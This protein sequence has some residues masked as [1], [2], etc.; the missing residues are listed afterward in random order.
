MRP[1]H[2]LKLR[3]GHDLG[4]KREKIVRVVR[5]GQTC[6]PVVPFRLR[7]RIPLYAWVRPASCDVTSGVVN[8]G[9]CNDGN[10]N[11]TRGGQSGVNG[12][13]DTA[14]STTRLSTLVRR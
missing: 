10:A 7:L 5:S 2:N 6:N 14:K 13:R 1:I 12:W 8:L 3:F 11:P 9:Q 4:E